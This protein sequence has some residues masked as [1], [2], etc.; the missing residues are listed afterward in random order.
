MINYRKDELNI[1]ME[2]YKTIVDD[3]IFEK[4]SN[5]KAIIYANYKT[6]K[7]ELLLPKLF[8]NYF[9]TFPNILKLL[10]IIYSIP[11]SSVECERGFSKQ[12][13]IKTDLRNNLNNETLNFLMMIGLD[14]VDL[15]EFDF[16]RA[17]EIWNSQCERR[18]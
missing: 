11:F 6:T 1:L 16:G 14:D 15:L 3:N 17:L 8:E 4:W 13:L 2:Y 9:E 12:N 10:S 7:L 5:Y 18:I